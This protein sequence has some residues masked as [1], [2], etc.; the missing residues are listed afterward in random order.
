MYDPYM[1][2]EG[3][4]ARFALG[5]PFDGMLADLCEA[6]DDASATS[7]IRRALAAYIESECAQNEG[8]RQRYEELQKR[9]RGEDD[10]V[11]PIRPV[12]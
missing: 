12:S 1:T 8:M 4:G 5:P 7:V 11:K 9:R 10:K 6:K 2:K 3:K